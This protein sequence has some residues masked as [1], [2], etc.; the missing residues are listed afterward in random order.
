[1][2]LVDLFTAFTDTGSAGSSL[3][4][5]FS[6]TWALFVC[7]VRKEAVFA[8]NNTTLYFPLHSTDDIWPS[9]RAVVAD[10]DAVQAGDS[11]DTQ[12]QG[13]N[14]NVKHSELWEKQ[15]IMKHSQWKFQYSGVKILHNKYYYCMKSSM[16]SVFGLNTFLLILEVTQAVK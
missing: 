16:F 5:A 12:G 1:M 3:V 8:L 13:N 6:Y 4:T 9:P 10:G 7:L 15:E 2:K 11:E 14:D